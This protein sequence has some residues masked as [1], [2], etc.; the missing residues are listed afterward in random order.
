MEV[1]ISNFIKIREENVFEFY[2]FQEKIGEG[3]FG[4]VY[5]GV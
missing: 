2:E 1:D 4:N 3:S 5:R